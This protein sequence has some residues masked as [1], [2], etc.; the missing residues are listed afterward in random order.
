[1][2]VSRSAAVSATQLFGTITTTANAVSTGISAIG[3]VFDELHLRSQHR[4]SGV[5]EQLALDRITQSE[6]IRDDAA[7]ALATRLIERDKTLE[8]NPL[9]KA[10][11]EAAMKKF[12]EKLD[13]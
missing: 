8:T 2:S 3:N 10:G 6:V 4:L 5:R 9:L 13:A 7:F 1:M 11:Y 12:A